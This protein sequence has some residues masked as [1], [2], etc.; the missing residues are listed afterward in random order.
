MDYTD[1]IVLL[2]NTPAQAETLLH[3]LEWAAAGIGLHINADKTEYKFFNQRGDF[4]TLNGSYLKLVDKF[5]CL[6]SSISSTETVINTRLTKAWTAINRLSVI[7]KSDL[8]DKMKRNFFSK[9]RSCRCCYMDALTA[10]SKNAASN[11]EQVVEAAPHKVAAVWLVTAHH[12]NYPS[13]TNQK[14]GTLL[15]KRGRTHKQHITVDPF[16]W[17]SKGRTTS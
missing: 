1:D 11:I 14:C 4:S 16:T 12:K 13:Q 10:I 7:Q 8:T 6:G 5:T 3:S 9:Q 17:T 15:E 2:V